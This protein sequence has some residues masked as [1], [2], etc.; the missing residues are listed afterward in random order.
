MPAYLGFKWGDDCQPLTERPTSCIIVHALSG[1]VLEQR[2][3][4]T[5]KQMSHCSL[6]TLCHRVCTPAD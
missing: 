3:A 5:Q 6:L 4:A 2:H 1:F